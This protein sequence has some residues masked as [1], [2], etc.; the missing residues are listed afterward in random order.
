MSSLKEIGLSLEMVAGDSLGI[1][2]IMASFHT[3]GTLPSLRDELKMSV[4]GVL[5][6]HANSLTRL[7]GSSSGP[8]DFLAFNLLSS[9]YIS[10]W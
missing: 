3:W 2:A 6:S 7:L 9:L 10:K 1:G 8:G 5:N 4:T